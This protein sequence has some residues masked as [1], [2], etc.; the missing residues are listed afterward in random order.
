M[1]AAFF[2]QLQPVL[3]A[4]RSHRKYNSP[5]KAVLLAQWRGA[6]PILCTDSIMW[7]NMLLPLLHACCHNNPQGLQQQLAAAQEQLAA[8]QAD[9]AQDEAI[10]SDKQ[11][12][13]Q[14]LRDQLAEAQ[15]AAAAQQ[16][17][18]ASQMV[19]LQHELNRWGG[20][21]CSRRNGAGRARCVVCLCC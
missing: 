6:R 1:R 12:E 4:S 9:L 11:R 19:H 15:E 18:A 8:A 3:L 7:D 2:D 10:F 21:G 13:L 14:G 20:G 16:A 5:Q 17:A